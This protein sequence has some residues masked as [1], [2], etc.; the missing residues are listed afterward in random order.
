[1]PFKLKI[2][3]LSIKKTIKYIIKFNLNERHK[4]FINRTIYLNLK[5]KKK[6]KLSYFIQLSYCLVYI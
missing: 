6:T 2:T 1:M 4:K 5:K 3:W